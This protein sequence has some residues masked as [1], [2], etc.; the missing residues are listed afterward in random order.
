MQY[1][2]LLCKL[3]PEDSSGT[4]TS[5]TIMI[6]AIQFD[7]PN[8]YTCLNK[9]EWATNS[10]ESSFAIQLHRR[11]R[12]QYV[13]LF[14][15]AHLLATALDLRRLTIPKRRRSGDHEW[16]GWCR[17]SW[18]FWLDPWFPQTSWQPEVWVCSRGICHYSIICRCCS[19]KTRQKWQNT[20]TMLQNV[21]LA[22]QRPPCCVPSLQGT[23]WRFHAD[24]GF[25][26]EFHRPRFPYRP[27]GAG[28]GLRLALYD[29]WQYLIKTI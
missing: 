11:S 5:A 23:S 13:P 21:F 29:I 24:A 25:H 16:C 14:V 22:Q 1:N 4:S 7:D 19:L 12:C 28:L 26:A 10:F 17:L 6:L 2:A 3:W 9:A 15:R 27:V 20:Q 18:T 8:D